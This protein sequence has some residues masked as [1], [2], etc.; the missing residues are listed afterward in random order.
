MSMHIQV[1]L[2]QLKFI[3]SNAASPASYPRKQPMYFVFKTRFYMR[4]EKKCKENSASPAPD[5][6]SRQ[7][8][9]RYQPTY[10]NKKRNSEPEEIVYRGIK[11]CAEQNQEERW[12][13]KK[14]Q[15][16]D[17]MHTTRMDANKLIRYGV[18]MRLLDGEVDHVVERTVLGNS[19]EHWLVVRRS[20]DGR[21]AVGTRGETTRNIRADNAID[22]RAVDTLEESE[23]GRRQGRGLVQRLKLLNDDVRVANDVALR[24][25]LLRRRVVVRVRVH[26]VA[27]LE[28][29]DRHRDGECL[30]GLD[31]VEVL[32][33]RELGGRH[34]RR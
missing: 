17:T 10:T 34:V 16:D 31:R 29:V 20:V 26:E 13:S 24:V 11:K 3:S 5:L 27:R 15:C 12:I 14:L 1:R 21:H 9:E 30:V 28:V 8:S 32:R 33:V 4:T 7:A 6:P 22:R 25:H 18:V 19:N 23:L 2:A